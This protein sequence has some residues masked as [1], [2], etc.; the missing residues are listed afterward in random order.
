MAEVVEL[1]HDLRSLE[2]FEPK[3]DHVVVHPVDTTSGTYRIRGRL[4]P[5]PWTGRFSYRLHERGFHSSSIGFRLGIEVRGGFEAT[6]AGD[7]VDV[8]HYE[9]YRLPWVA[10]PLKP[11][12][13]CRLRASQVA[14]MAGV[15]AYLR[16]GGGPDAARPPR[17][18]PPTGERPVV[19]AR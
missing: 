17:R 13:A 7:Q 9:H 3:A 10:L 11:W 1:L 15:A 8:R 2:E 16:A 14:E 6:A 4:G 19:T 5:L 18:P 12:L